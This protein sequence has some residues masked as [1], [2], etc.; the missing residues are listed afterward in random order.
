MT[1][2]AKWVAPIVALLL[3]MTALAAPQTAGA[4]PAG[5][6]SYE[7]LVTLFDEFR[8]FKG[9]TPIVGELGDAEVQVSLDDYS[10]ASVEKRRAQMAQYLSRAADMNVASWPRDRQADWLAVRAKLAE[11]D[12]MLRVSKPWE[13]DPG[14]YVDQMMGIT[15][16]NLPLSGD[17]LAATRRNLRAIPILVEAA[18][19]NLRNVPGDFADLALHNLSN[20]DGVGHGHPY[21]PVPPAG[22]IGWYDDLLGRASQQPALRADIQKARAAVLDFQAWLKTNRASMTAPAGV[23][24]AN[25]DWYLKNAKLLDFTAAELAVIGDRETQR[26]WAMHALEKH[27]NRKLPE[28]QPALT[29]EDYN[30]RVA[31]TDRRI[32]KFLV[33]EDIITIPP[34]INKLKTNV[35][36]IERPGGRNFWEEIQYRDPSPDHWHAVI[37]GHS[38]DGV[39]EDNNRH[40]IRRYITD[41]VRAEGWGVYLEEGAQ[42]LGYF[43]DIPR[44]RELIDLFG[45]FRAVRVNGDIDLQLNRASLDQV[46]ARWREWTPWLDADVARVDAEIYLRRPPGYG[47]GYTIGMTEMHKLLAERKHQL[48]DKFV[49]KAFHDDF[50]ARGRLPL[51]LLR[52]EITGKDDEVRKFWTLDPL[53][54]GE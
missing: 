13:R 21:R 43:E 15:F 37:P 48:G 23:G 5:S 1:M 54:A 25:F 45:I 4:P 26:L 2:P 24:E 35:P 11:H 41:G 20:A 17:A 34:Y 7:Q 9:Q 49:L 6:G 36:F 27:R 42:R 29:A 14:F 12:F 18:K 46:V 10:A 38:F 52:W 28:L 30:A 40:P 33:D 51:S 31:E 8:R 39:V 47:L 3:P 22:V 53:P 16:V 50:M 32:R 19:R 44:V